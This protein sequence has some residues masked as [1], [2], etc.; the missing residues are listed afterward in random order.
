MVNTSNTTKTI[1]CIII[2]EQNKI[3]TMSK[4]V[5]SRAPA[6]FKIE[7]GNN[8]R[9]ILVSKLIMARPLVFCTTEHGLDVFHG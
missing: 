7:T 8:A 1:K 4:R 3:M 2:D 9:I 6:I 5:K